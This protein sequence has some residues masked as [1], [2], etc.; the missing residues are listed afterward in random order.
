MGGVFLP[1]ADYRSL[2]KISHCTQSPD[3]KKTF[4]LIFSSENAVYNNNFHHFCMCMKE[5]LKL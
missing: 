3:H 5:L 4:W 1:P 2:D